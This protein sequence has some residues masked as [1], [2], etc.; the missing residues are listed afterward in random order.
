MATG[1]VSVAS[2]LMGYRVIALSLLIINIISFTILTAMTILRAVLFPASLIADFRAHLIGPGYF[3]AIAGTSVLGLQ[4]SMFTA[5]DGL[6]VGLWCAAVV[7]WLV[8]TYLFF[9]F[10]VVQPTKP[11]LR[12]GLS[13]IWLLAA[14][15]TQAIAVLGSA[16]SAYTPSF[17]QLILLVSTLFF[18]MGCMLYFNIIAVIFYRLLFLPI[19]PSGFTPPYWI[20]M[21]ATAITTQAGASLLVHAAESELLTDLTPFI[22][23]L[24]LFFWAAGTWWIPLLLILSAWT[25]GSKSVRFAYTPLLW[26]AV[27][28]LGMYTAATYQIA[29]TLHV[30][31]LFWVPQVTIFAAL[32]AWGLTFFGFLR[33]LAQTLDS[34]ARGLLGPHRA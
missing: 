11:N 1:I 28:P 33:Q 12:D 15:A 30:D 9:M 16:I 10:A 18:L 29:R 6:A 27:F 2:S 17:S 31:Q 7:L 25:Y 23:G 5:Y 8:I 19:T 24:S 26:G 14:V 4:I 22:S 3:T 32:L 20:N 21:G 13:G 34:V